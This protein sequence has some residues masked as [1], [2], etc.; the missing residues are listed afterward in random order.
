MDFSFPVFFEPPSLSFVV[1]LT[2]SF[3]VFNR[4]FF[5]ICSSSCILAASSSVIYRAVTTT[6]LHNSSSLINVTNLLNLWFFQWR[7]LGSS[8]SLFRLLSWQRILIVLFSQCLQ[9]IS[10]WCAVWKLL[11][12][13]VKNLFCEFLVFTK[14]TQHE[15]QQWKKSVLDRTYT[16]KSLGLIVILTS[17]AFPFS[18]PVKKSVFL[19]RNPKKVSSNY[20][21][22]E[23]VVS[24]HV[25]Q[26]TLDHNS[27]TCT[28]PSVC[29]W[30]TL[31]RIP[32]YLSSFCDILK[33]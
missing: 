21:H 4:S 16:H 29:C 2:W 14:H 30:A 23:G 33:Q 20:G 8:C 1:E 27:H 19:L 15:L 31:S 9:Q 18:T 10:D 13:K 12:A 28:I 11:K 17:W 6:V 32:S 24:A 22:H 5:F 25:S 3:A 7:F 26:F